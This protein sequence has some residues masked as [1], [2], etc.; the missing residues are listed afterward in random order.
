MS[1]TPPKNTSDKPVQVLQE[2]QTE[3]KCKEQSFEENSTKRRLVLLRGG[4]KAQGTV[5]TD[6]IKKIQ[7]VNYIKKMIVHESKSSMRSVLL[8]A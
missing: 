8:R 4:N 3:K 1:T 6:E 7:N 5:V 2:L